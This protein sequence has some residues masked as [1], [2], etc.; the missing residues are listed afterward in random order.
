MLT[1]APLVGAWIEIFLVLKLC[2]RALSLPLWE[3]GLK[4]LNNV[5]EGVLY[6]VAPLV[7][8]WIEMSGNR[9]L[10]H[11]NAVAPLVGAWIEI[12]FLNVHC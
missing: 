1:V 12:E 8:A 7:G 4:S 6:R 3:R 10:P 9:S 2:L 5:Q 11:L